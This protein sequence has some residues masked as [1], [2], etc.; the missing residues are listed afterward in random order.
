MPEWFVIVLK[1]V[2]LLIVLFFMTKWL[3]KKQISQLNIFEYI[4]GIVLGGIVAIHTIE[5]ER[6]IFYG[7]IAMFIWFIVPFAVEFIALKSKSFRNFTQGKSTV[8]I[9]DGKIMEEN[10]KKEGYSTDDLLEKLRDNDIF[11][12]SD[13]EFAVLEPSGSL[14]VLPKKEN[15]PL[16]AKDLGLKLA[17]EKEPQT[18]V[19]DGKVLLEPLANLSLNTNWL[20]TELDKLNVSIENVF[21]A[22]ADNNGQLTIDLYDDKLTVPQPTEAK[23]LL[24]TLKKCQA[25]LEL[26]A[27]ETNNIQSKELYERNSRKLQHA[28][29]LVQPYLK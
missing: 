6:N 10:L 20:E 12:A 14:S 7:I 17:P 21:L 27:L 3:G 11:L 19:M 13:V 1:S 24:A 18:V 2:I 9:Q 25:D 15:Q 5:P 26:F 22:Q 16:T 4:S 29:E 8:L 23:L 28:T